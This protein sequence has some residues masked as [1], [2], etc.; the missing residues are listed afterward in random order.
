MEEQ[1]TGFKLT[2]LSET[3]MR[4][5][6]YQVIDYIIDHKLHLTQKRTHHTASFDELNEQ[7]DR[8]L[9]LEG[10]NPGAVLAEVND[11]VADNIFHVDHPRFFSFIPGPADFVSVLGDTL[12]AGYNIFAGHWKAGSV[13]T[14]IEMT[15]LQW[16]NQ[17]VGFP[18]TSGG[19]FVS[20][21]SMANLTALATARTIKLGEDFSQGRIYYSEQT[22]A[23]LAKGLRILGFRP[24]Q[25]RPVKVDASFRIDLQDLQTKL[26]EDIAAGFRPFC[27]VGNAGTTNTGAVDQL[28]EMAAV[29]R[30][31][32]MW[33][34]I[35]GAHG[36]AGILSETYRHLLSGIE[37]ADSLTLDPHKWWFQTFEIGCV[38][39]RENR[40]LK[41][42]FAVHAEY[43]NDIR[44]RE[45]EQNFYEHGVQLTRS[46]R[47]LKLYLSLRMYGLKEF[48]SAVD[49]G[50]QL[51]EYTEAVLRQQPYW[52]IISP[53]QL[54][55]VAF[56]FAHPACTDQEL[57]RFNKLISEFLYESGFALI[58]TTE[59]RGLTVLRMCPIH[60]ATTQQDI[61]GTISKMN[62]FI[63]TEIL[64]EISV[65]D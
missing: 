60:P 17:L 7:M 46:F 57:D 41:E 28:K 40:H 25:M 18:E 35:D 65:R 50:F 4:E 19:I 11:W 21:G 22:H 16:L 62:G 30:K 33:F 1:Q 45:K 36:G 13:P 6:G 26:K 8:S 48:A 20:G 39:V 42:T 24:D 53:A 44:P 32:D 63:E 54:A 52:E 12:A 37:L 49:H 27:L 61:D 56:R 43:L 9:P 29:A 51:A 31:Y 59:L 64:G 58:L 47:S 55:I 2:Q 23:S 15:V 3:Q 10:G 5:L 14:M 38:L 34:H